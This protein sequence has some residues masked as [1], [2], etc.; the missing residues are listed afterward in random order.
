[1]GRFRLTKSIP[2][3][4]AILVCITFFAQSVLAEDIDPVVVTTTDTPEPPGPIY[5]DTPEPPGPIPTDTPEPPGPIPTDTPEPPGPIPTDSPEPTDT[6]EPPGPVPTDTPEPPGPVPTDTPEPPG[7]IP[8]PMPVPGYVDVSSSPAGAVAVLD[9]TERKNTP[10]TFM[11]SSDTYHSVEVVMS[12]YQPYADIV[13]VTSGDTEPV[14]AELRPSPMQT[15]S[16]N[17]VSTPSG[18]NIWIDGTYMGS[19]PRLVGGLFP[20]SHQVVL[21]KGGYYDYTANTAVSSG[22]V[23]QFSA[24]LSAYKPDPGVGWIEIT[25][26]PPGAAIFLDNTFRGITPTSATFYIS[27]VSPGYHT[28]RLTL[29]EYKPYSETFLTRSGIIHD[30]HATLTPEAPG[31][32]PDTD[33]QITVESVPS[34]A[35]VYLSND[36]RGFTPLVLT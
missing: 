30:I 21:R 20:G 6:P 22:Q 5:T 14:Y 27:D 28:V 36:F 7:P 13:Y 15:G 35:D 1:M 29:P 16:V 26:N 19:T 34:G 18:A 32:L 4:F 3:A 23:T 9:G 11:A 2:L 33:G 25:S 31:P 24:G 17:V 10:A 12:G 8:T